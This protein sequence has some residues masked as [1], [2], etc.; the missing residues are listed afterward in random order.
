MQQAFT[1]RNLDHSCLTF[2]K[3]SLDGASPSFG[4]MVI[5]HVGLLSHQDNM[6]AGHSRS[7][8]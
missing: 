3:G 7:P 5:A 4:A 6:A 8:K 1:R 2:S